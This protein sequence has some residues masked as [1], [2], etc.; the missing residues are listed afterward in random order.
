MNLHE[1]DLA[2]ASKSYLLANTPLFL[3][4]RLQDDPVVHDLAKRFS[5][6][7]LLE[8]LKSSLQAHPNTLEEV[9]W[10]YV[11]MTAIFLS[12]N[13]VD[14]QEAAGLPA[15]NFRWYSWIAAALVANSSPLNRTVVEISPVAVQEGVEWFS[16]PTIVVTVS[17]SKEWPSPPTS[18][19]IVTEA[20][21]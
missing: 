18:V 12:G 4:V 16:P 11:L 1:Y 5:S 10:P 19:A 21:S 14:L 7:E 9:V 20:K 3:L 8:N 17:E 2:N 13:F 15:S 6:T